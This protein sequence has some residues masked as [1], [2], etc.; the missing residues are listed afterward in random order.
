MAASL[1]LLFVSV[2]AVRSFVLVFSKHHRHR[3]GLYSSQLF[4]N[5]E[6]HEMKCH[7][8]KC[9]EEAD[10]PFPLCTQRC[11]TKIK[12][13]KSRFSERQ[14]KKASEFVEEI[15]LSSWSPVSVER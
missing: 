6:E 12:A 11:E 9:R 1:P 5:E 7:R 15:A 2:S 10:V 14:K 8:C 4:S 13:V 3:Q